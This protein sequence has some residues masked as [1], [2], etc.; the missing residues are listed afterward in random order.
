MPTHGNIGQNIGQTSA[1]QKQCESLQYYWPRKHMR[2][3]ILVPYA[4]QI[5]NAEQYCITELFQSI[6]HSVHRQLFLWSYH[7]YNCTHLFCRQWRMLDTAF[8]ASPGAPLLP[9]YMTNT[10]T[11]LTLCK[12]TEKL[13][14]LCMWI[15]PPWGKCNKQSFLATYIHN[16]DRKNTS[17]VPWAPFTYT[18]TH[19][20]SCI[21]K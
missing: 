21:Y 16:T 20:Q 18:H 15:H 4:L 1:K 13:T 2:H 12:H 10:H 11:T 14:L 7:H 6:S 5:T 3:H 9:T 17:A 19:V 8:A